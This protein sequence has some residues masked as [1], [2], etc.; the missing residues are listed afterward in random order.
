MH[1]SI[2]YVQPELNASAYYKV[3]AGKDKIEGPGKATT[4]GEVF[5]YVVSKTDKEFHYQFI[6]GS[7][8]EKIGGAIK[9]PISDWTKVATDF[10]LS[11]DT[12]YSRAS[13]VLSA[14]CYRGISAI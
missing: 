1:L 14:V 7:S 13:A 4:K 8:G 3:G 2:A 6:E 11:L 9:K 5:L 10:K 12:K